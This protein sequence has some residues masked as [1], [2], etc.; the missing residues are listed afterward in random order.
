MSKERILSYTE[1]LREATEQ[2]MARDGSVILFGLGV[3]DVRGLSGTTKGLQEKFGP[4]RVFDTPLSE[5]AMS[6]VAIGASLAG[7]RPIH[8]HVRMDFLMLAMNQLVNVAAKARYM[9]GGRVS[10]PIVVRALIGDGWG[11]QHSQGL[12]SFFVHV[13]GIKVVAPSTPYDAKG[14]LIQ[15]IR[16]DNPVVFVEHFRLYSTSGSVPEEL[17]VVP[18]GKA[19]IM[20]SGR[21]VTVVGISFLAPE[22]LR[23]ARLLADAGI[24][25]EV[26]DPVSLAPLDIETIVASVGKT[27]H[28]LVADSAWTTC[29]ASAEIVS[30]VV[31]RLQ[32]ENI[33]VARIGFAPA[34]SPTTEVLADLFYPGAGAITAKAYRLVRG[35][36]AEWTA[37]E[38][39]RKERIQERI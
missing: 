38:P 11:A 26:I 17:Y 1:A 22:C 37:T 5:D 2:E 39:D 25:A 33:R 34:P 13:P 29:G 10:V 19:K 20:R 18:F 27:K 21:D 28:L 6:G 24:D 4:E 23:A 7:L 14:C 15:S 35:K 8:T 32:G 30:R 16:D 3:D 31:E 36:D 12:Q 9:Y